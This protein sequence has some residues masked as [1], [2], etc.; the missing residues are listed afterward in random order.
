MVLKK[1][2]SL[3]YICHYINCDASYSTTQPDVGSECCKECK[4]ITSDESFTVKDNRIV[5]NFIECEEECTPQDDPSTAD[6]AAERSQ[7]HK[8]AA[9]EITKLQI[10]EFEESLIDTSSNAKTKSVAVSAH[11]KKDSLPNME[12]IPTSKS[13]YPVSY[14]KISTLPCIEQPLATDEKLAGHSPVPVHSTTTNTSTKY[15]PPSLEASIPGLGATNNSLT[16]AGDLTGAT[17]Y[18]TSILP[19]ATGSLHQNYGTDFDRDLPMAEEEKKQKRTDKREQLQD[20]PVQ[21]DLQSKSSSQLH[22]A[23]TISKPTA[24]PAASNSSRSNKP[25]TPFPRK[26]CLVFNNEQYSLDQRLLSQPIATKYLVKV[27]TEISPG[28]FMAKL[29]LHCARYVTHAAFS[30]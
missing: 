21:K 8:R 13:I 12:V 20:K 17:G 2:R 23:T 24:K 10:R 4:C 3:C 28:R 16:Q 30:D 25:K 7:D 15:L 27:R 5:N 19:A 11:N 1:R 6:V 29:V 9:H 14:T 18:T 26:A 22:K